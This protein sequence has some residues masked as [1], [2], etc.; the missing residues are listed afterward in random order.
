MMK[1]SSSI[2]AASW[3]QDFPLDVEDL[4]RKEIE[5]AIQD[6]EEAIRNNRYLL[7]VVRKIVDKPLLVSS[8]SLLGFAVS[9]LSELSGLVS[10]AFG[11]GTAGVLAG[12]DAH[13]AWK[14][15]KQEI[16]KNHLYFYYRCKMEMNS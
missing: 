1:L 4:V 9:N 13:R 3:D 16:E 6:I 2:R 14:K 11:I 10:Q 7:E 12:V 8:G 5:P 15:K